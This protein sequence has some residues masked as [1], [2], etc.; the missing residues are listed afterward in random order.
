MIAAFVAVSLTVLGHSCAKEVVAAELA[1]RQ[2]VT[3]LRRVMI[4]A[5]ES[6][7]WWETET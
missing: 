3:V 4:A 6:E 2:D 1:V 7:Y 5:V